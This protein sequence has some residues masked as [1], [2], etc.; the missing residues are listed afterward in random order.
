MG[1]FVLMKRRDYFQSTTNIDRADSIVDSLRE[2]NQLYK[3]GA[4]NNDEF[5]AAKKILLGI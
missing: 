1:F 3:K 2:L 5:M 4:L